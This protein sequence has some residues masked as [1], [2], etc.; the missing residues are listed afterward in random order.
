MQSIDSG[1]VSFRDEVFTDPVSWRSEVCLLTQQP[2]LSSK[3]VKEELLEA[4]SFAI[5]RDKSKPDEQ[6]LIDSLSSLG[7]EK[8]TLS[9][10]AS[11]LSPGEQQ[12]VA[13][14]RVLLLEPK[15]LLLDEPFS[16]LDEKS[17]RKVWEL[18]IV[19]KDK[20]VTIGIFHQL[21]PWMNTSEKLLLQE[22]Q[23]HG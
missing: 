23:L 2:K 19:G 22:G 20:R 17:A 5:H 7:L 12:R 3:T 4:F 11:S 10:I 13:V 18:L 15:C 9:R 16:A 6:E 14:L 8:E 1:Q 21:Y